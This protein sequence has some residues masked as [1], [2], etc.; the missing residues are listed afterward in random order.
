MSHPLSAERAGE[1]TNAP[2]AS[3]EPCWGD[4]VTSAQ[5][6][7]PLFCSVGCEEVR[8]D[9]KRARRRGESCPTPPKCREQGQCDLCALWFPCGSL[10]GHP[11]QN[12]A[13]HDHEHW[14]KVLWGEPKNEWGRGCGYIEIP[15]TDCR[16]CGMNSSYLGGRCATC[17]F[18]LRWGEL[19]GNT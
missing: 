13:D 9:W 8:R 18:T 2:S 15:K 14:E 1:A 7:P 12:D 6:S 19:A 11:N 5:P 4:V 10:H 17:H 16:I 3:H